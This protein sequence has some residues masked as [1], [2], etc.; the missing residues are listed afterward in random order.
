ML[1]RSAVNQYG[2]ASLFPFRLHALL[3]TVGGPSLWFALRYVL[4]SVSEFRAASAA[5]RIHQ[6]LLRYIV[7][8]AHNESTYDTHAVE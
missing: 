3:T 7:Q 5:C 6:Q 1:R 4:S 2:L 8:R